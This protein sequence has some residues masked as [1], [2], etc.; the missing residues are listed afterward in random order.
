MLWDRHLFLFF[1]GLLVCNRS[2]TPTVE[3]SFADLYGRVFIECHLH[4]GA[5]ADGSDAVSELQDFG[6]GVALMFR[7]ACRDLHGE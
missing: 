2:Q 7:A 6:L 3:F 4:G 5:S 1:L